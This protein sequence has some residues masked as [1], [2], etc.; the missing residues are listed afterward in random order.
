[1]TYEQ[2]AS[3]YDAI[4]SAIKDYRAEAD[5]VHQ[6]IETHAKRPV[7]RLLDVGCGTGLHD[8]YLIDWYEVEGIDLS[9][10]QLSI[11]RQRLGDRA[12]VMQA[13][14]RTF[15]MEEPS[16]QWHGPI[17]FYDAITC[18]FSVIGH[19]ES[20]TELDKTIA[21]FAQHLRPGGVILVEP[22]LQPGMWHEGHVSLDVVDEP[23]LKVARIGRSTCAGQMVRLELEHLVAQ[24]EG[25]THFVET[26]DL[27]MITEREFQLAFAKVGLDARFDAGGINTNGRGIYIATKPLN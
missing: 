9:T 12:H 11:A 8:Q 1:M 13:D 7:S 15:F 6:L 3:L 19:L 5:R 2:S 25:N 26:H 20:V 14:M 24:P 27:M 22:W 16:E 23:E 18:L 17:R 21:N 4:Y 10:A